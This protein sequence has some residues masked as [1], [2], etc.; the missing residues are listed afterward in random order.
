MRRPLLALLVSLAAVTSA[1]G[2]SDI[3]ISSIPELPAVELSALE[4][5]LA[6]SEVPVVINVW[7]S[8]CVPCRSEAPLLATAAEEYEGQIDVIG[9]NVRDNQNGARGFIAEFLDGAPIDHL[10]D[11]PGDIPV[12]LGASRAVPLTFFYAP[13]GEQIDVHLGILD[14]ATLLLG[15]DELLARSGQ[16]TASAPAGS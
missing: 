7:A 16:P 2:G 1:C 15:I 8:W 4:A 12:D 9:L 11:E 6:G 3:D 10:F 13:G 14:E 5:R